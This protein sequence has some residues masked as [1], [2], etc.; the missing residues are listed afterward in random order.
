MG[1]TVA[2]EG[3]RA[4]LRIHPGESKM[5]A[6]WERLHEGGVWGRWMELEI[7]RLR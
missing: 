2:T 6:T 5:E 4:T 3:A 7:T 1:T